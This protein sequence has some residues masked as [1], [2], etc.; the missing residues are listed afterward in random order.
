SST[1]RLA[2]TNE[3]SLTFYDR[4]N[5][6]NYHEYFV[7]TYET[8]DHAESYLLSASTSET[9]GANRTT[10][11]NE[12]TGANVCVDKVATDTCDIGDVSLTIGTIVDN[13]TQNSVVLTA[14]TNV[15]F[16]TI[17]SE[18]GLK[19]YLPYDA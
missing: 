13:S 1:N 19:I 18:E 15:N 17:F 11:K 2:T 7:A 8:T 14:G 12:L 3:S 6:D 16:N 9:G 10:I 4:R 5:S